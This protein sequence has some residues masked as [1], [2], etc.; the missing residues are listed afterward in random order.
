M[1]THA[2]ISLVFKL[3]ITHSVVKLFNNDIDNHISLVD[4]CWNMVIK[5]N[6]VVW[7]FFFFPITVLTISF[8][9]SL[10]NLKCSC[11]RGKLFKVRAFVLKECQKSA[12]LHSTT[13]SSLAPYY[14]ISSTLSIT[15]R[16]LFP[17]LNFKFYWC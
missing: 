4:S 3:N 14:V 8:K 9:L 13:V 6:K 15:V 16:V 5:E 17:L 11:A 7:F 2:F 12:L 1:R 10:N